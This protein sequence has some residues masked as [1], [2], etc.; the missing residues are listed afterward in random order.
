M[1]INKNPKQIRLFFILSLCL[2]LAFPTSVF[3]SSNSEEAKV[4]REKAYQYEITP[5]SSEWKK[6][7]PEELVEILDIPEAQVKK[8]PSANLMDTVMEYPYLG[9][10]L[11]FNTIEDGVDVISE[12]FAGLKELLSRE[13]VNEYLKQEYREIES[14]IIES[15]PGN[16]SDEIVMD[17]LLITAL[18]EYCDTI[19]SYSSKDLSEVKKVGADIN[20]EYD[21]TS[22][23]EK[24]EEDKILP[25]NINNKPIPI[26]T[27]DVPSS[28][29]TPKGSAVSTIK[30]SP[31]YSA[32]EKTKMNNKMAKN[33]PNATRERTATIFYNCH[34]YAWYSQDAGNKHL[35]NNP[36]KYWTDGSY[37]SVGAVPTANGQI[38]YNPLANTNHSAR[39]AT[40]GA[41]VA[42]TT[43]RS[44]WGEYGLYKH[45]GNHCPYYVAGANYKTY[46]KS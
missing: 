10:I 9:D 16:L 36:S 40:K 8:M 5:D 38:T 43:Y 13:D 30:R 44:K 34:S 3:A 31:D 46:K 12:R 17:R 35:M 15:S 42:A 45:K 39:V 26:V 22:G 37:K 2:I 24:I 1:S 7:D 21:L 25:S 27:L 28:V 11:A 18:M 14:A 41:S 32:A 23:I 19:D 20:E 33:Y 4:E 6:L 29:K